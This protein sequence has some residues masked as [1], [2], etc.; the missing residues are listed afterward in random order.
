MK[1]AIAVC[2]SSLLTAV[3]AAPVAPPKVVPVKP[4]KPAA[5]ASN[6]P[7][8]AP[9]VQPTSEPP[10]EPTPS[11]T[12][13]AQGAAEPAPKPAL[14]VPKVLPLS[15]QPPAPQ[16]QVRITKPAPAAAL[17]LSSKPKTPQSPPPT[18]QPTAPPSQPVAPAGSLPD[19]RDQEAPLINGVPRQSATEKP[20]T[21]L[22]GTL[23]PNALSAVGDVAQLGL[24]DALYSREQWDAAAAEYLKFIEKYPSSPELSAAM[25][26]LA[27]SMLKQ[28]NANSARLYYGKLLALPKAGP[29][30]GVAAYKLAEYEFQEEDYANAF[31]HYKK[32][33]IE[34]AEE[35]VR[36]S[37]Q[38]F[39]ARSLQLLNRKVEARAAY[40]PLADAKE[41]HPF[42]EASQFQLAILLKDA[43][44]DSE[45]LPRFEK[46]SKEAVTPTIK[47]ES[48]V[49]AAFIKL[50]Q[51]NAAAALPELEQS[52]AMPGTEPWHPSIRLGILRAQVSLGN[53]E[54]IV[55]GFAE[56]EKFIEL[57]QLPDALVL[58]ANAQRQLKQ[59]APA[60]DT[61]SRVITL[62]PDSSL[63]AEARYWRLVCSYNLEL[64][65]LP[66]EI[67]EF[68]AS[69]PKP[70]E[71]DN[72]I[73]MKAEFLRL[74]K[75][76]KSAA[77]AYG[78][79]VKS[80][81]LK[82]E[83][84]SEA[85]LRWS[86]CS[87]LI[88]DAQQTINA[89]TQLL[90]AAP[91]H[92][93][94]ATA[95]FWR[96]ET[97]RRNKA[98]AA[99]ERDYAEIVNKHPESAERETA[100]K[101]MALLRGEQN[102]HAGMAAHYERLL[103]DYPKSSTRAEAHHWIGWAAY[104]TKNYQKAREHLIESR[105]LDSD[106]YFESDSL[107]L[108]Y[109]CYNLNN[110][111]DFWKYVQEYQP[112][113][114]TKIAA[115]VLR[116]CAQ[117]FNQAKTPAKAEPVL[118]LITSSAEVNEADWFQLAETRFELAKHKEAEAAVEAYLK[119]VE[120][121]VPKAKG[122]L[123]R[124]KC[125]LQQKRFENAQ[126]TVEEALLLQPE[127]VLNGES[128]MIAGDIQAGQQAWDNAA[129]TYASIAV[130][131]DDERLVPLSMEKATAAYRSA[132]K[133]KEASDMLNKLQSRFPEWV[134]ERG[135][136]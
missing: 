26:R 22:P 115:D 112:K 90:A 118:A 46:L 67:D 7:A 60:V 68:L 10:P 87:V 73:L 84:R 40:A 51:N 8:P 93:M 31:A 72:A 82:P 80:K 125:E 20:G 48:F 47:M 63:A 108:I 44:R 38:Y 104:E 106:K 6:A 122:L 37:A 42:R 5:P 2:L 119:L 129:K 55:T 18:Q 134:R 54:K 57:A 24:A 4:S 126:K 86:E 69:N 95:L 36:Q 59:F 133:T 35:K 85:L 14:S 39:S 121:P 66:V 15:P 114:K 128:R 3:T 111:D 64:P 70:A 99:A 131:F 12:P 127:G 52:L 32:A 116:W 83:R 130:V 77:A 132:G 92:P 61:Y 43:A 97:Q 107:R 113:G 49:R 100:L 81:E 56:A 9:P 71:R 79:A 19:F 50:E 91:N 58:L 25:Y 117:H 109:C 102:D 96:A 76:Y 98:A 30:G 123:I 21:R 74:R 28:G 33:S 89:T 101:Q 110:P 11:T 27:E 78:E 29:L 124:A 75:D 53:A 13:P 23:S 41:D 34:I 135:I 17:P 1:R 62:A 103:A 16:P 88:G 45:A 65:H 136:R 105:K 94:A 120:H